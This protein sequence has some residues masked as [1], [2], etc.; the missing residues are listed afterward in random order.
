MQIFGAAFL[1]SSGSDI[2]KQ[3]ASAVGKTALPKCIVRPEQTEGPYFADLELERSDIRT[4]PST[5]AF[6]PG[7]PLELTFQVSQINRISVP[8]QAD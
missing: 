2:V 8:L 1:V 7:L 4:E 3:P 6:L 5:G